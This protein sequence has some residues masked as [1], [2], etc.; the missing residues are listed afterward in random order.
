MDCIHMRVW[1]SLMCALSGFLVKLRQNQLWLD[2]FKH[3]VPQVQM[4][5]FNGTHLTKICC[6]YLRCSLTPS[7][8]AWCKSLCSLQ[9]HQILRS[10][11]PNNTTI[12]PSIWHFSSDKNTSAVLQ[13]QFPQLVKY[14]KQKYDKEIYIPFKMILHFP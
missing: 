9:H 2:Y 11:H 5:N 3:M 12:S 14:T 7:E 13:T 4:S 8:H 6:E 1:I 10:T